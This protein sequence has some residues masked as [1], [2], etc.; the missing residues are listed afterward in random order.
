M[1]DKF[2]TFEDLRAQ[3]TYWREE[4]GR[5]RVATDEANG[6]WHEELVRLRAEVERLRAEISKCPCNL[7]HEG[8]LT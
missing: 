4:A 3:R 5:A 1:T 2:E 7:W 6:Y 8:L